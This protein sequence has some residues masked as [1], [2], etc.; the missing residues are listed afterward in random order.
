MSESPTDKIEKLLRAGKP[1][2]AMRVA[3]EFVSK[4]SNPKEAGIEVARSAA[5]V[6]RDLISPPVH[7]FAELAPMQIKGEGGVL[8][9][10]AL[11]RLFRIT[12]EWRK[13]LWDVHTERLMREIREWTRG[14]HFESAAA[15]IAR[16]MAL[17][18]DSA[19]PRRAQLIGSVLATIINHQ[20]EALELTKLLSRKPGD[21]FLTPDLI[22]QLEEARQQ[23]FRDVGGMNVDNLEREWSTT[24]VSA[25]VEVQEALPGK[26]QTGEPE[27]L[28]LRNTGDIFRSLLRIPIEEEQPDLFLDATMIL[29]DFIP[30]EETS[31]G[32]LARIEARSYNNLGITAKKVVLLTFQDIG[33]NK[34]FTKIYSKWAKD[35][36]HTDAI[37]QI[38]EVMG[39]FRTPDFHD[40]LHDLRGDRKTSSKLSQELSGALGS[41]GGEEAAEELL[42]ELRRILTK[43]RIETVDLKECERIIASLGSMVKSPRTTPEERHRILDFLRTHVPEDLTQLAGAAAL[44]V[45]TFKPQEQNEAQRHFAVRSL[46]R[47]IWAPDSS[48]SHHKGQENRG[49]ELGHRQEPAEALIKIGPHDIK[50]LTAAV[51]PLTMRY[52]AAY[53]AIAEVLSQVGDKSFVSL[54]E[55]MLNNAALHDENSQSTYHQEY[56]WDTATQERKPVTKGKIIPPLIHAIGTI[57]GSEGRRT[58]MRYKDLIAA[59]KAPALNADGAR[60]MDQFLSVEDG[61]SDG[62]RS[63]SSSSEVNMTADPAEIDNYI[64]TL[65]KGFLLSSKSTRRMKKV[66]ALSK[67]SQLAPIEALDIVLDQLTDKDPMVVSAAI[68][69][70][71]EFGGSDKKKT[72]RDLA[73]NSTIDRVAS[74]D[75]AMRD[76]ASKVLKEMGP[77]RKEVKEKL[78]AFAKHVERR[79]VKE[80]LAHVLK[81]GVAGSITGE[82]DSHGNPI[83][84]TASTTQSGSMGSSKGSGAITG[85]AMSSVDK[86]ELKRQYMQA[87]KDWIQGGKKG[88][89]PSPPPGID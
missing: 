21:Y 40:F 1:D 41:M 34:F 63:Q 31:T 62:E 82:F 12:D 65:K 83:S 64:K 58:L 38:V 35:Y 28:A 66:E 22:N 33:T 73:I 36:K 86:L 13:R 51:D 5:K 23:R 61:G 30:K 69:C 11:D 14:R 53:I 87:R 56:Y 29:T 16:L 19:K 45:F 59:G 46:V 3:S 48:T 4:A 44:K 84:D 32:K 8:I 52:G 76:G 57:G 25:C 20:R 68:S 47:L 88:D 80:A 49:S 17:A 18:D 27:E 37:R 75:P 89:P 67:L 70:A 71:A 24:L 7:L 39:A 79:E 74:K 26:D 81:A 6:Y 85:G 15:N 77:L 50:G 54:L 60:Y 43:R 78:I 72:M 10:K 2:D 55:R 42:N 9:G